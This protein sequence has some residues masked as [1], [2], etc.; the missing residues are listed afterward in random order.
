MPNQETGLGGVEVS[1]GGY[2]AQN[3]TMGAASAGA[4]SNT[5]DVVFGPATADWGV[6]LGAGITDSA[7]NLLWSGTFAASQ[8][9]SNTNQLTL[10]AG[11]ITMTL[12]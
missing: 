9:V 3:V 11:Q 2:A 12:D 5:A 6:V 10:P 8:T 4:A 1:A 7:G